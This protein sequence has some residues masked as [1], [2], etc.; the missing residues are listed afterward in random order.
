MS[1]LNYFAN[2]CPSGSVN[3]SSVNTN[4]CGATNLPSVGAGTPELHL[5]LGIF[6]G[7]LAAVAV[8]FIIIGGFR[9]VISSGDPQDMSKAKN[10]I[11]YALIGLVVAI[12]AEGIVSFA[13]KYIP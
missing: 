12:T 8:L 6:F 7:I 2:G 3:I 10:T 9:Y 1:I 11:L 13:L 5:I 4:G